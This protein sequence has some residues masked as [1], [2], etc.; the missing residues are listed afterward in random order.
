[1][2]VFSFFSCSNRQTADYIVKN[3]VVYTVDSSF[4][5]ADC[6]AVK[7]GLFVAIGSEKEVFSKWQSENIIDLN[8]EPVFP[9]FIDAHC[10]F[11]GYGENLIKRA[12]LVGTSSFEEVLSILQKWNK[13]YNSDWI[14]GRGWDQNDWTVK[15]FPTKERLDI[16]F[17]KKPVFLIRIDG[18]AAVVN[19][20][21]LQLAGITNSTTVEGGEIVR[22]N[23]EPT[24]ILI[25]NAMELV[26]LKIPKLNDSQKGIALR[27]AEKN[28]FEVGLTS[29]TDCGLDKSDIFLI[30]SL[31][32]D[33][34]LKMRITAML[35]P[36]EGN[37]KYFL[38][39]GPYKTDRLHIN[40]IKLYADG[41]LG[42]RGALLLQPYSDDSEN[43]GIQIE[44]I[45][46]YR[47]ICKRAKDAGFQVATHAIGDSANRLML[48]VYS[49]FLEPENDLRWRI[50]H[51][52]II[53]PD[54]FQLF[55]ENSIIPSVQPTH[56]TSDSDW[57]T[58]RVGDERIK[59]AYAYRDL[60]KTNN[61]LP[62]GTD[63]PIEKI[64][65]MLTFYAAI[66]R[67]KV[68]GKPENGFLLNQALSRKETLKGMTIWAAKASFEE[69]EKGSIEVGKMADFVV[70]DND[71]M[72]VEESL[73]PTI[74]TLKT[75]VGG[76]VVFEK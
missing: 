62:L 4:S 17:P 18:H 56:A 42:S 8:G 47:N 35:H 73:I 45:D 65:P 36:Y 16:L 58:D 76:D 27:L 10:H 15:E 61:W 37:L 34:E 22:E 63:F 74:K 1:M 30:D 72:I 2:L 26:M 12:N 9:G 32:R 59:G 44:K 53:H 31:Q 21:A 38:P 24:G 70:L 41:A 54:D 5:I 11:M 46:Y 20:A 67:K 13:E 33:G 71:I 6:F 14:L 43:S 52:Q 40:A 19:S 64:D 75:V 7:D 23:G 49:E 51:S 29:V 3:G 57:A 39:K 25:D 28:C 48:T 50:E 60:L 66:S 68:D 69:N 55:K